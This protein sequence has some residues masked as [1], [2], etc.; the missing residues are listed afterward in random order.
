MDKPKPQRD[1]VAHKPSLGTYFRLES[2]MDG[3]LSGFCRPL[4]DGWKYE[5]Q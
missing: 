2:L 4:I 3:S 5:F 1:E